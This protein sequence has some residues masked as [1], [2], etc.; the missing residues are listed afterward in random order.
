MKYA[1]HCYDNQRKSDS[2]IYSDF[3][4][5]TDHYQEA[6]DESLELIQSYGPLLEQFWNEA[7]E[8][9]M[10]DEYL[11]AYDDNVCAYYAKLIENDIAY[12]VVPIRDEAPMMIQE[13][14]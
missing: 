8:R 6:I 9:F 4:M 10:D 7:T 11:P 12:R 3:V 2:G 5:E 14:L 13:T 1:I